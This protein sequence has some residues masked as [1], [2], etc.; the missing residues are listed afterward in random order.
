MQN[1]RSEEEKGG[2]RLLFIAKGFIKI[3]GK[4]EQNLNK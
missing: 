1:S 2:F 3:V 4:P